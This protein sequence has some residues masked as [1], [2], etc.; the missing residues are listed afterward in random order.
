MHEEL[1]N[2][3]RYRL[4]TTALWRRVLQPDESENRFASN[5]VQ[6]SPGQEQVVTYSPRSPVPLCVH[7][8]TSSNV[9]DFRKRSPFIT[10]GWGRA[11]GGS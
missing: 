1:M 11:F 8:L 3:K 9:L 2:I 10:N 4:F 6:S 5:T 7:E